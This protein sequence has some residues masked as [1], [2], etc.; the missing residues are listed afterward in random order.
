MALDVLV[1]AG[2]G[3]FMVCYFGHMLFMDV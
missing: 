1:F 3:N 2:L